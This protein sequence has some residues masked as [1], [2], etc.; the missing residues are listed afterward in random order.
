[1][2]ERKGYFDASHLA[3]GQ[4]AHLIIRAVRQRDPRQHLIG[5]RAAVVL[6]DAV[7]G[8]MV[9]QILD[10]GEIEIERA[11]LEYD[12]DHAQSLA[13]RMSD[14][15]AENP[16]VAALDGVETRDQREQCT[17]SSSIEAEQDGEGRWRDGEGDV[18][19]RL[20]PA[21]AMAHAFDGDGGRIDGRHF[22]H[23][24]GVRFLRRSP[25]G[26]R[27]GPSHGSPNGIHRRA[28]LRLRGLKTRES[29]SP[30]W[31][32][33]GKHECSGF[34]DRREANGE[35][36]TAAKSRYPKEARRPGSS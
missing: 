32:P 5:A 24:A 33:G 34:S 8:C 30:S 16:D 22:L 4:V 35:A 28:L 12:A 31:L 1:M 10:H 20:T 2:Q 17:L 36:V 19:E 9:G 26:R 23:H 6:A 3:A 18:V 13:R 25:N 7:Q 14:V 27:T 21:V 11:L 29:V 15:V